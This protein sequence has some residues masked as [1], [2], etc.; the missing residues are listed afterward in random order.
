MSEKQPAKTAAERKRAQ[1]QRERASGKPA[2]P[3]FDRAL[4]EAVFASYQAG[5]L[6][7]DI[8]ELVQS[9]VARVSDAEW[10]NER[11]CRDVVR[12][13]LEKKIPA[14]GHAGAVV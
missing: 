11:G 8:P 9:V 1:R 10:V 6:S 3:D 13:L 7:I 14:G 2:I 12:S 5:E 4:R